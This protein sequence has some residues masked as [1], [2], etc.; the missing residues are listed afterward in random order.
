MLRNRWS[1]RG[2]VRGMTMGMCGANMVAGGFVSVMG[3]RE[4][5]TV[6]DGGS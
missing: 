1:V 2:V 5:E 4:K 6:E 3:K